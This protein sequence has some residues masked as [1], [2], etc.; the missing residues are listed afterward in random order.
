MDCERMERKLRDLQLSKDSF[1]LQLQSI[2]GYN[3]AGN[4]RIFITP[5]LILNGNLKAYGD[6]PLGK[7]HKIINYDSIES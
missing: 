6:V 4:N 2:T 1:D 3:G 5:A 7:L